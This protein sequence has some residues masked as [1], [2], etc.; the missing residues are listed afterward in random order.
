MPERMTAEEYRK[1]VAAPKR[2]RKYR[3]TPIEYGGRMYASKAQAAQAK[4]RD[5]E[6]KAGLIRGWLPEVSFPIPGTNRRM[7]LDELV[8]TLDGK[9]RLG[10]VKGGIIT[11]DWQL[12]RE[13]LERHLGIPIDIIRRTR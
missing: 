10:D 8:V 2:R 13:I 3:N 6:V 9:L 4:D 12:K 7:R 5:L 11:K 1:L